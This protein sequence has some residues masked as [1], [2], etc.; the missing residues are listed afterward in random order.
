[1]GNRAT[2]QAIY[3]AFRKPDI[4]VILDKLSEKVK[5]EQDALDHGIPWLTPGRGKL[6]VL[7]F[8]KTVGREFEMKAFDVKKVLEDGSLVIALMSI[9][10]TIR[11]TGKQ[12]HDEEVHVWIFDDPGKVKGFRHIVD[13]HQHWLAAKR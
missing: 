12:I 5:W 13:T 2:V 8:F 11:S 4:P 3:E 9:Q 6:H 1:M 10:A 7:E